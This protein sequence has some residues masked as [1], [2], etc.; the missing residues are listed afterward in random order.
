MEQ[1]WVSADLKLKGLRV[2]VEGDR[3]EIRELE[4]KREA[5]RFRLAEHEMGVGRA[6]REEEHKLVH[7]RKEK[8]VWQGMRKEL[9]SM[10]RREEEA[11]RARAVREQQ[12][13]KA[14]EKEE[15]LRMAGL[16]AHLRQLK[17]EQMTDK[18]R[19]TLRQR[20][21]DGRGNTR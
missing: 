3:K 19:D 14:R 21:E 17:V 13:R 8:E 10:E 16:E 12:E 7:F 18:A 4:R 2:S 20:A 9:A 15:A 6:V 1:D 11:D 5:A